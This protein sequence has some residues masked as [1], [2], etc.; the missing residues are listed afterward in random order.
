[1]KFRQILAGRLPPVTLFIGVSSSLPT[2]T[3]TTSRSVKPTNQ[4]SLWFWLVPVFPAANVPRLASR[5]VPR[6]TTSR[7]RPTMS[8]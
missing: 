5:P 8:R 4:A 7:S 6:S 2:Q 1:M 3:P